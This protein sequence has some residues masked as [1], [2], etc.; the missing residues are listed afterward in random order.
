LLCQAALYSAVLTA[1][2]I[3]SM[4]MLQEDPAEITRDVLLT[5]TKQ[6]ANQSTP[7]FERPPFQVPSYALRVNVYLFISILLSLIAALTA[8]LALQWVSSYDFG[9]NHRQKPVHSNA[10]SDSWG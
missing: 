5:I 10:T 4:N 7:A 2:I 3:E 8:V 6:L 9:L 1:F